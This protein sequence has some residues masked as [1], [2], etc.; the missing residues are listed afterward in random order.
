MPNYLC[1]LGLLL[2]CLACGPDAPSTTPPASNEV[3]GPGIRTEADDA[4][5][6]RS[7]AQSRV[8][9]VDRMYLEGRLR[10]DTVNYS[11]GDAGGQFTLCYL[12][13]DLVKADHL[14]QPP[15]PTQVYTEVYY[16]EDG[17]VYFAALA[18]DPPTEDGATLPALETRYYYG[19]NLL[20]RTGPQLQG[21]IGS[22]ALLQVARTGTYT[23]D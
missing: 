23:C 19:G 20:D 9:R 8:D 15:R 5:E 3:A 6:Q 17:E 13:D 11:C 7:F 22:E 4:N 1:G 16:L 10:C 2:L 14:A 21:A 18:S 12:A